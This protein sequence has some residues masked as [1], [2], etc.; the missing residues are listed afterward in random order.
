MLCH[1]PL[2]EFLSE[3][4]NSEASS[5]EERGAGGGGEG[6][7]RRGERG[8]GAEAAP[9]PE[10]ADYTPGQKEAVDK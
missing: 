4:E 7:R 6:V 2:T 10:V 5:G 1:I 8:G 9:E 3:L